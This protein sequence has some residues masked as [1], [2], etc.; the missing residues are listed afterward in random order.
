[1][2]RLGFARQAIRYRLKTERIQRIHPRVYAIGPG[3]LDQRGRWF[4]A[5]LACRPSPALSHLSAAAEAG[6]A[7][8]FGGIH[9][10][11]P[12]RSPRKL[13]GVTVHRVRRLDPADVTRVDGLP[14]TT[15]ARTLLD[16]AESLPFARFEAIFEEADRREL[17]DLAAIDA[18]MRRNPGRRG[19]EPLGRLLADYLPVEGANE[20]LERLFQRFLA[21]EGFP[22]PQT[23]VLVDGHLVDCHWPEHDF[24]V[25]LDSRGFHTHWAQQERDKARDGRLLRAGVRSLRVTRHRITRERSELIADLSSQLPRG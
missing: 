3:P 6:L 22:Q 17:L 7:R 1:M 14:V 19:L 20:G 5:L 13:D 15:L 11:I 18:C 16:L 9:V 21:E 4:A 10:T 23:N 24:V 8:E 2:M 12:R 25:E